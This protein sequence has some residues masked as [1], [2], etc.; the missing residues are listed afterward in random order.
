MV[1]ESKGT[2]GDTSATSGRTPNVESYLEKS[3]V[4]PETARVDRAIHFDEFETSD[5]YSEEDGKS[6]YSDVVVFS[7]EAEERSLHAAHVSNPRGV[8]G[9]QADERDEE[10]DGGQ[11]VTPR[12]RPPLAHRAMMND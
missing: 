2:S 5:Q 9:I 7:N 10:E 12:E 4:T 11:G 8:E 1:N 6:Y 3:I